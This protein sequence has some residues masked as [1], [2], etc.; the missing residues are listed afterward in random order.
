MI[1]Y[2]NGCRIK[3]N[4]FWKEWQTTLRGD[5]PGEGFKTLAEAIKFCQNSFNGRNMR[6]I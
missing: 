1:L 3:Y 2:I 6:W 5:Y 4:A